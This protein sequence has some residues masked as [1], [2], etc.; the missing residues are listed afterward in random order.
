MTAPHFLTRPSRATVAAAAVSAAAAVVLGLTPA[1][2]SADEA[3]DL[4]SPYTWVEEFDSP[5]ALAG[6]NIFNQPDYNNPDALY[7]ADA[8]D[9]VDGQLVITTRR[10]CVD[11]D[12]DLSVREN[13]HLLTDENASVTPCPPGQFQKF[14]SGRLQSPDI[15]RGEFD[16]SV[17]ATI[18]T[19]DV[20]GVRSAIWLQ[21]DQQACSSGDPDTLYGELDL[22]EHFSHDA[23][24]PW[25]PSNTHLGCAPWKQNG[26]NNAPRELW[27]G[28]SLVDNEHT[29][30]ASTSREGVA[31]FFDDDP[32]D[33]QS[34]RNDVTLGHA[35]VD[36]FD[37]DQGMYDRILDRPW[38]LI[39]N[40]KV[41]N[42]AW[43]HPRSA[44]EDFPV[45]TMVV[46]R[47]EVAGRPFDDVAPQ[48]APAPRQDL[49][50]RLSSQL[51]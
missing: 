27:V 10:H 44:D 36:D 31:Y 41:E 28:D 20:N 42:A 39:L 32:I 4:T 19:G 15:A 51:S 5:D 35:T 46:D 22:V 16:V 45:R 13:H 17:T 11:E 3:P 38:K 18:H 50:S 6:W 7:T 21:N 14:T 37:L 48:P 2:A 23:R 29:W 24:A 9:V 25:S 47:I 33:R 34:W 43:T 40:Q 8:L 1:P 12:I 26:T 49:S 30:S